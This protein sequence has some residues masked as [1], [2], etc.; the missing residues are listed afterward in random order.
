MAS[1]YQVLVV[2]TGR[3]VVVINLAEPFT[4]VRR[5]GAPGSGSGRIG[6]LVVGLEDRPALC[7]HPGG[8]EAIRLEFT[9]LGAYRLFA[10]P[11]RELTNHVVELRDVLGPE[12]GV[13]VER[14]AAAGDWAA[15]FDL[16][17]AALL[18]RLGRGPEPA[19]EVGHAWRLLSSTAGAIPV[20]RIAAEVGWSQGH[21]VRR[22][23]EQVGLTPKASARVLRFHRAM[24]M[25][26]RG[27]VNLAEISAACGFY[28]QAHLSREFRALADT[29]PGRMTAAR[30]VEGALAL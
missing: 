25:L 13:L 30:R 15:R 14:L 22:F 20:A 18:A 4:Q 26:S 24:G 2:P 10:V 23:T 19:P 28:D 9:P 27:D 1:P 7:E 5:L 6:S 3:A 16:L 12:A 11:M 8:Q 21:L 29:T 17:D